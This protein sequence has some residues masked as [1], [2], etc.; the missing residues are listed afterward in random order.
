M[1]PENLP[2][3]ING[4]DTMITDFHKKRMKCIMYMDSTVCNVCNLN[5]LVDWIPLIE[6]YKRTNSIAFYFIFVPPKNEVTEMNHITKELQLNY[7][8][9]IDTLNTF[10][11]H[12]RDITYNKYLNV[13]LLDKNRIIFI[14]NPL[15]DA[16]LNLLFHKKVQ[17]CLE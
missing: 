10:K 14:G 7:P 5:K 12:N 8:I 11:Q 6:E 17:D 1:I 9:I 15:Y 13:F 3:T 4:K 2:F 16:Q